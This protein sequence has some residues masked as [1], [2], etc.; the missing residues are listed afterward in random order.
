[1]ILPKS[2]QILKGYISATYK[3]DPPMY[4]VVADWHVIGYILYICVSICYMLLCSCITYY[5]HP[6]LAALS[7][8]KKEVQKLMHH[9]ISKLTL[10]T[11]NI[12]THV[13]SINKLKRGHNVYDDESYIVLLL[14]R[15][16]STGL[17]ASAFAHS[18]YSLRRALTIS[19][20]Y[21]YVL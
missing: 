19:N 2:I 4:I 18:A 20:M 9:Y 17:L 11:L 16:R 13:E 15:S 7:R 5:Y 10:L 3:S 1:M 8:S 14:I 21:I 6:T 12:T